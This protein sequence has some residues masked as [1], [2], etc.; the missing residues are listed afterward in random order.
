[1]RTENF[2]GVVLS[3]RNTL[4]RLLREKRLYDVDGIVEITGYCVR[5]VRQLCRQKKVD[6]H[7]LLGRYYMTPDEVAD[8]LTP[9][10][11]VVEAAK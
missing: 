3:D 4:A 10:K 5:Y 1:M 9:V 11:K 7:K 8:L 2:D 6:H